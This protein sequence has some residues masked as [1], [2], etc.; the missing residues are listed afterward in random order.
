MSERPPLGRSVARLCDILDRVAHAERPVAARTLIAELAIPRSTAYDLFRTLAAE[1]F[2]NRGEAG[3]LMLGPS[4]RRL[5]FAYLGL[6]LLADTVEPVLAELQE[7]TGET[8]EISVLDRGQVLVVHAVS[9]PRAMR[10]NTDVG[11]R[12]PVNWTAAGRVLLAGLPEK[13]LDYFLT[14]NVR[15]SPTG[16]AEAN[17][18]RLKA[19]IRQAELDGYALEMNQAS[20]H[21]GSIAAPVL[22][23][24]RG[25]AALCLEVPEA[26]LESNRAQLIEAVRVAAEKLA[27]PSAP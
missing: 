12:L 7:A 15:P 11:T 25:R 3:S 9:G 26:R 10:V 16:R 20:D 24:R 1:G 22:A 27:R 14:A 2:L 18:Q 13:Q 23:G 19:E 4:A 6:G 5:A 21:A 17:V 8:A